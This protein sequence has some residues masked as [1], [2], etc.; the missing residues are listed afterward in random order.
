MISLIE[1]KGMEY[2]LSKF[3]EIMYIFLE[4]TTIVQEYTELWLP[5]NLGSDNWDS[6]LIFLLMVGCIGMLIVARRMGRHDDEDPE[7]VALRK[8]EKKKKKLREEEEKN[9]AYDKET[10]G[11]IDITHLGAS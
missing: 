9:A 5:N 1:K 8:R 2:K 11:Y 10:E 7:I 3:D 4:Q 6:L